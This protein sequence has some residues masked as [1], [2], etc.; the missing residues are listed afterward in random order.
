MLKNLDR[1]KLLPFVQYFWLWIAISLIA[2]LIGAGACIYN[3]ST[4]GYPLNRGIDFTGGDLIELR[5]KNPGNAQ[6]VAAIVAPYSEG[7]ALVQ[8]QRNDPRDI[9]IR[10]RVKVDT[11]LTEAQ[12]GSQRVQM[13]SD[14]V[15]AV[16]AKFGGP[17][18]A[19]I[20]REEHV[21]PVVGAELIKKAIWALFWGSIAIMMYIFIRFNMRF[22]YAFAGIVSLLHDVLIALGGAALLRLEINSFFIAVI[23]TIIGYSIMDTII[24][25]DRIRENERNFPQLNFPTLIN[26]SITQTLTRSLATVTTV[27]IMLL[28]LLLFGGPPVYSFS[29]ALLI[30]VVS[31]M[32]SSIF[33]AAPIVLWFTPGK[34]RVRIPKYIDI[35]AAQEQ[36]AMGTYDEDGLIVDDR[37]YAEEEEEAE[38]VERAPASS[39]KA[40]PA[41]AEAAAP[42]P[43]ADKSEE[44]KRKKLTKKARKR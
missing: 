28:A 5:L 43:K 21:G 18:T 12:Q 38:V 40:A 24:V 3:A 34:K 36:A 27:I 23:L 8:P 29:M 14:M 13:V 16:E 19:V 4:I 7:E 9:E 17:G 42:S 15:K 31:G 37:E 41:K 1:Y 26:L 11:S 25:Y 10:M 39:R 35:L 33:I 32:Y 22:R 2:I 30:G 44:D 20:L 6:D